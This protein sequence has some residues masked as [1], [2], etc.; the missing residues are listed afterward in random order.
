MSK[1]SKNETLPLWFRPQEMADIKRACGLTGDKLSAFARQTVLD[2]ARKAIAEHGEAPWPT[3]EEETVI[4]DAARK[5]GLPKR[6]YMRSRIM[7]GTRQS[8]GK[9]RDAEAPSEPWP[10]PGEHALI[11]RSAT[12]AGLSVREYVRYRLMPEAAK[13]LRGAAPDGEEQEVVI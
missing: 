12:E 2:A 6:E 1:K 4:A 9:P 11:G 8:L 13:T 3:P 10:T 5:A 7:P